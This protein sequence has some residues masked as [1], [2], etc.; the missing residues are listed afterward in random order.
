MPS[1][2][3]KTR[4]RVRKHGRSLLPA[5]AQGRRGFVIRSSKH[6][7]GIHVTLLVSVLHQYNTC[8]TTYYYE[9]GRCSARPAR[10]MQVDPKWPKTTFRTVAARGL[11][12]QR[13]PAASPGPQRLRRLASSTGNNTTTETTAPAPQPPPTTDHHPTA[14]ATDRIRHSCLRRQADRAEEGRRGHPE[15][16]GRSWSSYSQPHP[17]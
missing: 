8:S 11:R 17:L 15:A 16:A 9:K 2:Q 13:R 6:S 12:R 14:L 4:A 3:P 10:M 5:P 1:P 7:K